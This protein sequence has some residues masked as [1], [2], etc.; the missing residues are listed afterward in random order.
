MI[1]ATIETITPEW[2][3]SVLEDH[4]AEGHNRNRSKPHVSF[5][6]REMANDRWEV[7]GDAIRFNGRCLVDGQHRL[8][9][10]V[11]SGETIR[12]LVVRGVTEKARHTIDTGRA[13]T[14]ADVLRMEGYSNSTTLAAAVKIALAYEADEYQRFHIYKPSNKE[15]L[16]RT[17]KADAMLASVA[18]V[19]GA[20]P[21]YKGSRAVSAF[22]H[23]AA[24]TIDAGERDSFFNRYLNGLGL[25]EDDPAYRLRSLFEL[26]TMG[27]RRMT[28]WE[29][30]GYTV[31]AWNQSL[32]GDAV[33]VLK[34]HRSK[35]LPDFEPLPSL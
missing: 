11:E 3:A 1:T 21:P 22:I 23:Y 29:Q 8:A 2:A 24:G 35:P 15:V 28:A 6:A 32:A 30:M 27:Q 13:R 7:N 12:S 19:D 18:Y 34:L 16:E 25:R 33:K 26:H 20:F 4:D 31:R 14:A 17:D 10:V 9:A 5:L